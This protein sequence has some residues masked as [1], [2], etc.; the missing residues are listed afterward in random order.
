MM[1]LRRG[2]LIHVLSIGWSEP[3]MPP[4]QIKAHPTRYMFHIETPANPR[5]SWAFAD[6][7]QF[8]SGGSHFRCD[9]DTAI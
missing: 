4:T 8:R 3:K 1:P 9:A 2:G 5:R 7:R 6:W